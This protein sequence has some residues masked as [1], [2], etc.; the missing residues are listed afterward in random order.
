M[1]KRR[2]EEAAAA[3]AARVD[4][5]ETAIVGVNRYQLE[6]EA[7]LDILDID[8]AKVRAGQIRRLEH[9]SLG[10][11]TQAVAERHAQAPRSRRPPPPAP[12]GSTA[13]RP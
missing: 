13:A 8:N 12:R 2:I 1:P 9:D 4:R 7:H 6:D 11:M 10:G 3:R 5:G